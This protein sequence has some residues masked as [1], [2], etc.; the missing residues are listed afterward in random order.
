MS[1][2]KMLCIL[3]IAVLIIAAAI[4]LIFHQSRLADKE[5]KKQLSELSAE[6]TCTAHTGCMDTEENSI[7][8]IEAGIKNGAQIVEFDLNFN[9]NNEPVLSHDS[10]IGGEVTLEEAFKKVSE[11]DNIKVNVDLKSCASLDKIKMT[12]QQ[13]GIL[14]R[15]FF[16]GVNDEFLEYVQKADLGIPYYLNVNVNSKKKNNSEYITSLVQ[17]VKNSG[18]VGIN[19]NKDNVSVLLVETFHDNGLLVSVWTVDKKREMRKV[20]SYLPDNITTRNPK[21][22]NEIICK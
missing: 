3:C 2:E 8:A 7:E 10:P 12:A 22:L 15:I 13:Y 5:F 18:A 11:Y 14:D 4:F 17:K 9:Q 6:F 16:T 21:L 19:L 1:K 20:V